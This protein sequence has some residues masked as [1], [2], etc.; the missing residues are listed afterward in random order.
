MRRFLILPDDLSSFLTKDG[1]LGDGA[2]YKLV[3]L[4]D[5]DDDV[6]C[7]EGLEIVVGVEGREFEPEG[8]FLA[9][10]GDVG[11]VEEVPIFRMVGGVKL[12]VGF[13]VT[14]HFLTVLGDDAEG[15]IA[16]VSECN[17]DPD[18]PL[19]V[20]LLLAASWDE[21]PSF[22]FVGGVKFDSLTPPIFF[23]SASCF[24]RISRISGEVYLSLFLS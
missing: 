22:R 3:A 18:I 19:S 15:L 24:L 14:S 11:F 17:L 12:D 8:T 2:T 21:E 13:I 20:P 5:A 6:I 10:D 4:L 1:D 9:V 16:F 23:S 7:K